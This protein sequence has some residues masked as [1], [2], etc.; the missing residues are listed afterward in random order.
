MKL[1]NEEF[2]NIIDKTIL[3]AFDFVVTYKKKILL[4]KRNN[5]PAKNYWFVPGGRVFK[6]EKMKDA[7][8]RVL[9]NEINI[10]DR[11]LLSLKIGGLYEHIYKKDN[12]FE[13]QSID[14]HYIVQSIFIELKNIDKIKT[15][16]QNS[17]LRF[18]SI[19]EI[20]NSKNVHRF[21][22]SYF[23]SNSKNKLNF[24]NAIKK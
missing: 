17:K 5:S 4:L 15:D 12:L 16:F 8:A 21:V 23:I 24:S 14:T 3:F 19:N 2:K 9:K 7:I 10:S 18:F 13:D 1:N 11:N 20:K 6:N 22:K